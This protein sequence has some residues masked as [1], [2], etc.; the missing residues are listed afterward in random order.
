MHSDWQMNCQICL[1][2]DYCSRKLD[3]Y[4]LDAPVSNKLIIEQ[5]DPECL[6]FSTAVEYAI[7][8]DADLCLSQ[9]V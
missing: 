9:S 3:F 7:P 8:L 2:Y 1:F 4:I 5:G 6:N